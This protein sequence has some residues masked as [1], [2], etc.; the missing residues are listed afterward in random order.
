MVSDPLSLAIAAEAKPKGTALIEAGDPMSYRE[1][2]DAVQRRAADLA[3]DGPLVLSPRPT[4]DDIVTLLAAVAIERPLVLIHPRA[5]D[6]ERARRLALLDRAPIP[7]G[8]L[9]LLFTSGTGGEAKAAVLSRDAVAAA[10][11]ANAERHGWNDD[12][13]WALWLPPAH[14]GGLSIPLRCV[15]GRAAVV[16]RDGPFDPAEAIAAVERD[17]ITL[18]SLVPTM[19]RRLLDAEWKPPPHLRLVLVGGAALD[20]GLQKRASAAGVPTRTTYGMTETCAQLATA[21]G[22]EEPGVGRPMPTMEVAIRAGE[23]VARGPALFAGYLGEP[24]PLDDGGWFATGDAGRL[25][26][27]GRLH[28]LGRLDDRILTGGENVDPL[29]VERALEA[30]P[31]IAE[32]AVFGA[33]DPEWGQRVSALLV[34]TAGPG[35]LPAAIAS[36]NEALAGH[37]RIRAAFAVDALPRTGGGKKRRRECDAIAATLTPLPKRGGVA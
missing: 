3:G 21:T 28:V 14:I 1:L 30:H 5:S 4:T 34:P 9:A 35:E 15:Q 18:L 23:I 29:E 25:D 17:R 26:E 11:R 12:D 7:K 33:P 31:A 16:L 22:P 10:L 36:V 37:R 32:A 2:W 24:A 19:L 20:E 6:T 13:R 8:T 27:E